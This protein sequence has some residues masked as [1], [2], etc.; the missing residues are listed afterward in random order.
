MTGWKPIPRFHH[1]LSAHEDDQRFLAQLQVFEFRDQLADQLVHVGD[2]VRHQVLA[3]RR[4]V[5]RELQIA[6]HAR[7]RVVNEER[8]VA[9]LGDEVG[10]MLVQQVGHAATAVR[11][12]KA[13]DE[14]AVDGEKLRGFVVAYDVARSELQN[15]KETWSGLKH[16]VVG[17][18]RSSAKDEFEKRGVDPKVQTL[19]FFLDRKDIREMRSFGAEELT[20]AKIAEIAADAAKFAAGD[21]VRKE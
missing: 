3:V 21:A 7:Q 4:A 18:G 19:V 8:I 5:R 6:M 11:I 17:K 1:R 15:H 12:A 13:L 20:E 9:V 14:N 10:D 2:V 16:V